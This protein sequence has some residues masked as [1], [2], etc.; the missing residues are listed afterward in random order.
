MIKFEFMLTKI[1]SE[2]ESIA[3]IK[4]QFDKIHTLIGERIMIEQN[5][6]IIVLN[7]NDFVTVSG[8]DKN[9]EVKTFHTHPFNL[10][11]PFLTAL[12]EQSS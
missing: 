8:V 4:E 9:G 1:L 7:P 11:Q 12:E 5:D 6:T 10:L 3:H 2:P